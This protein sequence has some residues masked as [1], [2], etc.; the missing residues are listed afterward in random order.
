MVLRYEGLGWVV[1]A[2]PLS[3]ELQSLS[4]PLLTAQLILTFDGRK[5]DYH[6]I[7]FDHRV[8][9]GDLDP[10]VLQINVNEVEQDG[11]ADANKY[12]LFSVDPEDYARKNV[13]TVPRC[14]QKSKGTTDRA[15]VNELVIYRDTGVYPE[16]KK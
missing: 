12:L 10:E 16:I 3:L 4:N 15:R 7:T 6:I 5:V 13:L 9:P 1:E 8:P 14:C 11:G 2:R